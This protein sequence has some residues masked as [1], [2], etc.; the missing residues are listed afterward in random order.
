MLQELFSSCSEL[1]LLS[2]L[3]CV[4]GLLLLWSMGSPAGSVVTARG[5]SC[6]AACG[7]LTRDQ[8]AFPA[9]VGRFL[10]TGPP[11]KSLVLLYKCGY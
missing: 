10:T 7:Q 3:R 5:V 1:G 6:P 8:L 4:R 11:G 2:Q 9:L